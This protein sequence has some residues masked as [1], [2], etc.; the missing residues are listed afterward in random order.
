MP[1]YHF[2]LK[3]QRD[4]IADREGIELPNLEAA[5]A[6]AVAVARDMMRN[7]ELPPRNWRLEVCD[8]YLLPCFEIL[9]AEV[10]ETI[11]HFQPQHRKEIEASAWNLAMLS[12]AFY[13]VRTSLLDVR[14]TLARTDEIIGTMIKA[15]HDVP[16]RGE[17]R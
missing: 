12:D 2:V 16:R 13:R 8:D 5:R 3:S 6:E 17:A 11:A 15:E 1:L 10:D 7:C 4:V 14:E 9:F